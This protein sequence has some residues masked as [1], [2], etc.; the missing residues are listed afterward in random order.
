MTY[1]GLLSTLEAAASAADATATYYRGRASDVSLKSVTANTNLIY[2]LDTMRGEPDTDNRLERWSVT[3]A[4]VRQDS[5]SSE[6]MEANQVQTGEES[7]ETIFS[8][9]H[10]IARAFYSALQN[11][12]EIQLTGQP[13]YTQT[14]RELAGTFTGWAL[15]FQV[16]LDVGCD[17][18]EIQDAIYQNMASAPT[19][20]VSIKRGEVYVAGPIT[21]TD[22]DGSTYEQAA[23]TDVVCTFI[24]GGSCTYDVIINGV[25][26]GSVTLTNCEDLTITVP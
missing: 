25:S 15:T 12:D 14:T 2:V 13:S 23:N 9:T 26:Q 7:R 24:P 21:V 18:I 6:S 10:I 4:F 8:E 5:T 19:F 16:W 3:V 20:E 22:S 17:D 11:E 1:L